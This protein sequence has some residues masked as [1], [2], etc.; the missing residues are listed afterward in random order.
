MKF[1]CQESVPKGKLFYN[2]IVD[3]DDEFVPRWYTNKIHLT[4]VGPQDDESSR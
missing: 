1:M 2:L 4:K 3:A